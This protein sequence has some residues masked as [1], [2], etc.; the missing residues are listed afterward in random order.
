MATAKTPAG[1]WIE[2]GLAALADGGPDAV[3]VERLATA[4]GVTKGGF[5]WHFTDRPAFLDRLL[6][7]W[8]RSAVEDVIERIES[9]P[10]DARERLRELGELA[11]AFAMAQEGAGVELA[12]RDWARRDAAVAARLRGVDDRRMSYMRTL[13]AEFCEDDLEV[14]ARCLL[15]YSVFLGQ[16][17]VAASHGTFA[18]AEVLRRVWEDLLR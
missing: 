8:E 7:H 9:H 15:A 11:M 16:H 5:Y 13:F 4:L 14:E 12:V 3:R 18:R 1:A 6:D 10:A 2:A 17:F